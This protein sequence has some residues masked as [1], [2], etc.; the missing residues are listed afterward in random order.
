MKLNLSLFPL[1]F[2]ILFI[3]VSCDPGVS[4]TKIIIN[5]TDYD[6]NLIRTDH[7]GYTDT[8][9]LGQGLDYNQVETSTIGK[10]ETY[11]NC[12]Q[13]D[14]NTYK[15]EVINQPNAIISIEID[16]YRFW[17]FAIQETSINGGGK[18]TCKRFITNGDISIPEE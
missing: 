9:I 13:G 10:T 14:H 18:C 17:E 1:L 6:L 4:Y 16:D 5:H 7:K 3:C 11:E 15:I 12:D 8:I 2:F